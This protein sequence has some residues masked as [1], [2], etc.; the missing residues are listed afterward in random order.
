[1]TCNVSALKCLKNDQTFG[2]YLFEF[3]TFISNVSNSVQTQ[4]NL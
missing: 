1:M 3:G 4:N 2:I